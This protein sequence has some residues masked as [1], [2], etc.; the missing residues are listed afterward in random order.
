MSDTALETKPVV[1]TI[2]DGKPAV[3]SA[4][5]R[6][7]FRGPIQRL[8]VSPEIGAIIGAVLVWAFFW[9]NG[10]TFGTAA[11][12]L[13]ILDSA[14]PLGI[15]AVAVALL[16][17]GGE[18]DLS[19]GMMTGATGIL[20]GLMVKY[21]T[22]AGAPMWAA[23]GAAF[24]LAGTIG[25]FNGSLVNRTGLPSFIVTLATFF[26]L[27]GLTLVLAKRLEGKV[28]VSGIKSDANIDGFGTFYRVFAQD[29]K[30]KNFTGRDV[31][32]Y[33]LILGG[34]VFVIIGLCEQSFVRRKTSNPRA[35]PLGVAG[36]V[37]AV[38]GFVM[39]HKTDGVGNNTLWGVVMGVGAI[40][41]IIGLSLA[42]YDGRVDPPTE[43]DH[44]L[45]VRVQ[46][47]FGVGI[48]AL[49]L[50]CLTPLLLKRD[51]RR[52]L[53]TW[54][55]S[56]LRVVVA[57]VG[58]ATGIAIAARQVWPRLRERF[59]WYAPVQA[60]LFAGVVG[61]LLLAGSLTF[62]Q[63]TTVQALRAVA[64]MALSGLGLAMLLRARAQAGKFS[65]TLQ[66]AIGLAT[67]FAVVV[68]AFVVRLDSGAQRFRS[69]LFGAMM[70]GATILA[71]NALLETRLQKR[72][73]PDARADKLGKRLVALGAVLAGV[74]LAV[75]IVFT[76][77]ASGL[78]VAGRG[79]SVTRMSIIW[80][81]VATLVGA[82]VLTKTKWGNWIF[83][84][85]GNKEAARA[86]GVP[87]NRVK[88][89]L[90]VT[91]SL[92]GCFVGVMVLLRFGSVQASQGDGLE[93]FYIIAAVVG[94]NLLTGG[95][96][97][98][99]GASVGA[100]IM[101]MSDSGIAAAGWNQDGK[102]AF[103]GVVLLVAVLVN[104]FIRKKAQEAR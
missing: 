76:N 82:F 74:G 34:L 59:R 7:A 16:M 4:D 15:M 51:E 64:M 32:F 65:N 87:A 72:K 40:L 100:L 22:D 30:P 75:R 92:V 91:V 89:A 58:A 94:G 90:F 57:I 102:F 46:E 84:V 88:T 66:L 78:Q 79:F 69:G 45:R 38:V 81:I 95:Y 44:A 41:G 42:R 54:F 13:I 101:T 23:I 52:E 24:V 18:F 56:W 62:F 11:T 2:D 80:W 103:K 77:L 98:V 49:L 8:L 85:G 21:F 9:G 35:V 27:K 3:I 99:V 5:E 20:V 73:V 60:V 93:F 14:A 43:P 97:S 48:G 83:A 47:L 6:I 86:I 1:A 55:P 36:V 61:L 37:A 28:S 104:N 17:I 12:T 68:L 33:S 67:A 29:Y 31:S 50:A 19:A 53:L 25:F 63:L 39:L 26:V 71:A 96:G 70:I 10:Q